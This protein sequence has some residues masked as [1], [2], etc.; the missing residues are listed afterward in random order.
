M[1]KKK[2]HE[3]NYKMVDGYWHKQN[4]YGKSDLFTLLRSLM[5][6][7]YTQFEIKVL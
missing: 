7:G 2:T 5:K 1:E 6:D 3:V 4:A